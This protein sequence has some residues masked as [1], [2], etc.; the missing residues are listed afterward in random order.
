VY[1]VFS[2]FY[3]RL[4]HEGSAPE[5]QLSEDNQAVWLANILFENELITG[6]GLLFLP[7]WCIRF[8]RPEQLNY[9]IS[10]NGHPLS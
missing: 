3:H 1:Q 4:I 5:K 2:H 8:F 6:Y 7:P 9:V 10:C